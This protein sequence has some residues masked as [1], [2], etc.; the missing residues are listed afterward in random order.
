MGLGPGARSCVAKRPTRF[1][2][3]RHNVVQFAPFGPDQ[4][5]K[6]SATPGSAVRLGCSGPIAGA[7]GMNASSDGMISPSPDRRVGQQEGRTGEHQSL[8]E[9]G[10]FPAKDIIPKGAG[11][12]HQNRP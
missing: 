5:G 12:M 1:R 10:P 7:G 4:L 2:C 8:E 11:P 9:I 3:H 6:S